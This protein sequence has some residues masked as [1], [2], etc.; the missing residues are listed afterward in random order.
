MN[1][2]FPI[3]ELGYGGAETALLRL[4]G[5]LEKRHSV[6]IAVFQKNY[7]DSS[8]AKS[9]QVCIN[10]PVV[11]LDSDIVVNTLVWPT[12]F[13][14]WLRRARGLR[15]LK[16]ECDVCISFLGGANFLNAL[17]RAGK[18]C[19]LSERGSKRNDQSGNRLGRWIWYSLIDP[20]LYRLADR[21]VC[22]SDSLSS[23]IRQA[24]SRG[25]RSKVFTIAGYLDPEQ[26][27]AAC[28]SSIEP[29]LI[30]LAN[31]PMLV[32][33]GRLHPTK[34]FNHLLSLFAQLAPSIP[35]S[36]LLLI[37]DGPQQQELIDLAESLG[38]SVCINNHG[39][40]L[41][42]RAQVIFLGYRSQP[43]RYTR[44]GRAFV[45]SSLWE[46]LP[47]ILLEALAAGCW[48]LAANCGGSSEVLSSPELGQL[49]PPIQLDSSRGPW[50]TAL[51]E[52]LL[53]PA[54][55][56]IS[57]VRRKQLVDRFSIQR[58]AQRWEALLDELVG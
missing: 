57:L 22:V 24:V 52:A 21:I 55:R 15:K 13:V 58:S 11:I 12:Q 48:S 26:A 35:A 37:G 1:I 9:A 50:L 39:E 31:R 53:I 32:A 23:E 47:N 27:L 42:P 56:E 19:V 49:L 10:S 14:R 40:P 29:E 45:L 51:N 41:D 44:L 36:G 43:A 4:V 34:G 7:K 30:S 3:P 17:V 16:R 2:L 38:L 20:L 18:P 5:E 54:P 28:D 8:Y 6:V 25:R 33:A 46:G